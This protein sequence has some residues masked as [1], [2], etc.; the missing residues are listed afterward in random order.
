MGDFDWTS[1]LLAGLIG[2]LWG[3]RRENERQARYQARFEMPNGYRPVDLATGLY[4][5]LA[6]NRQVVYDELLIGLGV[7]Q[8]SNGIV[9][10]D[11]WGR[12]TYGEIRGLLTELEHDAKV[13]RTRL[14]T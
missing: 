11:T 1:I 14:R 12:F 7:A 9:Y 5:P 8:E 10:H 4:H 2:S 3:Q 13:E 6:G